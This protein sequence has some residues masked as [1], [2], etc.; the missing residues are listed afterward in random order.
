VALRNKNQYGQAK[1][2][3]FMKDKSSA[4]CDEVLEN[5]CNNGFEWGAVKSLVYRTNRYLLSLKD[6]RIKAGAMRLQF[7]AGNH[8]VT[9][10]IGPA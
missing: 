5:C 4:T 8:T 10:K 6:P 7:K 3:E 1:L 2:V 9:K